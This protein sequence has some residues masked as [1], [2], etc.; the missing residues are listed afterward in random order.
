MS[1]FLVPLDSKPKDFEFLRAVE[2]GLGLD[3]GTGDGQAARFLAPYVCCVDL[4]R[5]ALSKLL[6]EV[7]GVDGIQA[8]MRRMDIWRPGCF[9]FI[10]C[11]YSL[12]QL[13]EPVSSLRSWR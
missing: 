11:F 4:D 10:S 9:D 2:K 1:A 6:K 12:Q 3:L 13:R 7:A 8:D 5:E